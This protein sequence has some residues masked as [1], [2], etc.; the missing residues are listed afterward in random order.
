MW[1]RSGWLEP[2]GTL[3]SK[4]GIKVERDLTFTACPGGVS[5]RSSYAAM[6]IEGEGEWISPVIVYAA[7][8][9]QVAPKLEGPTITLRYE[10][11]KLY[12]NR[13]S[14]EARDI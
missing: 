10:P 5:V 8:I 4:G 9:R 11:G 2:G 12:L 13:T 3:R 6:D 1:R 14:F 7:A